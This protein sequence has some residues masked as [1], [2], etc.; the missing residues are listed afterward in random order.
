MT[1]EGPGSGG[2]T[3][4]GG[5]N[6]NGS[7]GER[8]GGVGGGGGIVAMHGPVIESVEEVRAW[9]GLW[10]CMGGWVG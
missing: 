3:S 1:T 5:R 2:A 10:S 9:V 4:S 7:D 6:N 8:G